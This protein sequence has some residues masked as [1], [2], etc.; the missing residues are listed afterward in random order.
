[1]FC[2]KFRFGS[3]NEATEG[4]THVVSGDLYS[5]EKGYGFVT[6]ENKREQEL[7]RIPELN[8]AFE[9]LYWYEGQNLTQVQEDALGCYV[10]SDRKVRQLES[11]AGEPL[12][13]A[14]R[15]IPL[16]FK[17]NVPRA[18]NYRVSVTLRPTKEPGEVLIFAGRRRLGFHKAAVRGGTYT[19][20]TNVCDI[21]PAWHTQ[22]F[23]DTTLDIA[24]LGACPG[25]H[26]LTV[27]ETEMPVIYL[28][29]DSTVTDQL[30]DYPYAPGTCYSGWGQMLPAF[31][32][33]DI[34]VSN[35][36]HS[37]LTTE[38]FRQE[39]HY[40][41]VMQ[42]L[43]PG[44][45]VFLQFGHN[46]QKHPE[47][48]AR[49]GYRANLVRYIDEVQAKGALPV[50]V[51]PIARNTWRLRDQTYLDLLE[52]FA[53]VCIELGEQYGIPVPDLHGRSLR[54]VKEKGLQGAKS[55]FHPG[56]YTHT[57]DYGA[58]RMAGYVA[59]EIRR[60]C[61][62]H[63]VR[64]YRFLAERVTD[65]FGSWPPPAEGNRMPEK[66][67]IYK[68]IPDP[69]GDEVLLTEGEQLERVVRLCLRE[70]LL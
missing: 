10:D 1:M 23:R 52:D 51:T 30:S 50:L 69:Q 58:Y 47:L 32:D 2:R 60:T 46:D 64:G 49:G 4:M 6:E 48:Q 61:K 39:G 22:V 3:E 28:A 15:R 29:G 44:D 65:G 17:V 43:R 14:P 31:L 27:E 70:E 38:T 59:E 33:T 18:G 9:P 5:P 36:A 13:G 11:E 63:P 41:V 66:P 62:D 55:I 54:Y 37:G 21:V 35:H 34:A 7:L 8:A 42:Y 16:V 20:V 67:E 45:F 25:L 56:D 26:A 19:M 53:A 40:A 24:V 68:D 57:N 12:P